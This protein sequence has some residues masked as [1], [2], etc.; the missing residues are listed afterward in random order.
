MLCHVLRSPEWSGEESPAGY[1]HLKASP[2]RPLHVERFYSLSSTHTPENSCFLSAESRSQSP[3]PT[4]SSL[5]IVTEK[6]VFTRTCTAP[7]VQFIVERVGFGSGAEVPEW[8]DCRI[9]S[10]P[11]ELVRQPHQ[12][13]AFS[14]SDRERV[15][16]LAV[17]GVIPKFLKMD[18]RPGC[19]SWDGLVR[20]PG[21]TPQLPMLLCV[22]WALLWDKVPREE[23]YALGQTAKAVYSFSRHRFFFCCSLSCDGLRDRITRWDGWG[24]VTCQM[25]EP[26]SAL[27]NSATHWML[28]WQFKIKGLLWP[29]FSVSSL[30]LSVILPLLCHQ[31][32]TSDVRVKEWWRLVTTNYASSLLREPTP[33]N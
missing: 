4:T 1:W 32:Q 12:R 9:G 13:M 11:K 3:T 26:N 15:W 23:L 14:L 10:P 6:E 24:R 28:K 17:L 8:L 31:G 18:R 20:H 7:E 16:V 19:T 30:F 29:S 5:F 22:F 33:S 25:P 2:A 27:K 21:F